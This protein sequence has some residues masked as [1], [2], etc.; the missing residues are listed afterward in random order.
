MIR[1]GVVSGHF[2]SGSLRETRCISY[3]AAIQNCNSITENIKFYCLITPPFHSIPFEM[4][5]LI[6]KRDD[7]KTYMQMK[8][9]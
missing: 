4:E 7:F 6:I 3:I 1:N 2:V 8:F 9:A 5:L